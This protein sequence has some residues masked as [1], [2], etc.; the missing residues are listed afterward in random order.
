VDADRAFF[1]KLAGACSPRGLLSEYARR[2]GDLPSR[3]R[4]LSACCV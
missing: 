3:Q 1:E 4:L 2:G